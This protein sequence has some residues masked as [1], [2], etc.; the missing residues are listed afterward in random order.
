LVVGVGLFG[1]HVHQ[2]GREHKRR[3]DTDA[4]ETVAP[5]NPQP[6]ES[7]LR[8]ARVADSSMITSPPENLAPDPWLRKG[9]EQ[10]LTVMERA[11]RSLERVLAST[12]LD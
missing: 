7:G 3:R 8:E 4:R 9:L 11:R 10:T 1:A 2:R 12:K 6:D 5:F